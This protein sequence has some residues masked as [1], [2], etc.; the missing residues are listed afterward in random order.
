MRGLTCQA[1]GL[2]RPLKALFWQQEPLNLPPTVPLPPSLR[3][4]ARSFP[5]CLSEASQISGCSQ[6]PEP[7][8]LPYTKLLIQ[9]AWSA[10]S[11]PSLPFPN[12]KEFLS[13]WSS[14]SLSY[15]LWQGGDFVE[16][17]EVILAMRS[18]SAVRGATKRAS[19]AWDGLLRI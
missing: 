8:S 13:I 6:K 11:L 14:A 10:S 2:P 9:Q 4:P 16:T 12:K 5:K 15:V 3:Q 18:L 1:G 19:R 17:R 7:Q